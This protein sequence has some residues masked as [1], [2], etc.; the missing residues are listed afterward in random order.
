M[1]LGAA[2]QLLRESPARAAAVSLLALGTT[3]SWRP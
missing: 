1:R 2:A 3:L